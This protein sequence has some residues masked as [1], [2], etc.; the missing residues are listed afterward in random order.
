MWHFCDLADRSRSVGSRVD[1]GHVIRAF[2]PSAAASYQPPA[3]RHT[4]A[5]RR[6]RRSAAVEEEERGAT[7][8]A[9]EFQDTTKNATPSG[10]PAFG[11]I[12]LIFAVPQ[13]WSELLL[14][15]I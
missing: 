9:G 6:R 8:T 5:A 11:T 3:A 10:P 12:R 15:R 7:T 1:C 13:N 14:I 4:R 2:L